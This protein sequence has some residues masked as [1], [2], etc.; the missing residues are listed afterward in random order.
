MNRINEVFRD[1][2]LTTINGSEATFTRIEMKN[3]KA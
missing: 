3:I 2:F 1:V